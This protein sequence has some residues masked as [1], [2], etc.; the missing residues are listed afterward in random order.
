MQKTL[1]AISPFT[2][3]NLTF[4]IGFPFNTGDI[5]AASSPES[6]SAPVSAQAAVCVSPV[7]LVQIAGRCCTGEVFSDAN[8]CAGRAQLWNFVWI[9]EALNH[10]LTAYFH[11]QAFW[12]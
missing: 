12:P 8:W 4:G 5:A 1:D 7:L 10:N 6:N 3:E 11:C 2:G 9:E